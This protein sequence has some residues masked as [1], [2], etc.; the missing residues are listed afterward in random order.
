VEY[1]H[2]PWE[3][4]S[5]DE[6]AARLS[7]NKQVRYGVQ[8]QPLYEKLKGQEHDTHILS[9]RVLILPQPSFSLAAKV[10]QLFSDTPPQI[11]EQYLSP[12]D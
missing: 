3:Y 5:L 4:W 7:D 6:Q 9:G 10:Q 11:L 2:I 12:A 8:E 1:T